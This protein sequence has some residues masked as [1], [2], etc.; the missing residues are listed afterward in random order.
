MTL[1]CKHLTAKQQEQLEQV[2]SKYT[3]FFSGKLGRYPHIKVHLDVDDSVKPSINALSGTSVH[4]N[5]FQTELERLVKIGVLEPCGRSEWASPTFI[6]PKKD[7]KVRWISDLR[8]LNEAIKRKVYPPPRIGDILARRTG[9][10]FFTKLDCSMQ[11]CAFEF[12]DES[13]ELCTISTPS[14]CVVQAHAYGLQPIQRHRPGG[15]RGIFKDI[16]DV[17][18][19]IDDV[20]CFSPDWESHLKLLDT[21]L[22]RLEEN[23]FTVNPSK[24]EWAVKETDWLGHWLTPTGLKPWRKKVDAIIKMQQPRNITQLR[25]FIGAVQYYRDMWPRRAHIL[26]PLTDLTGKKFV[27]QDKLPKLSRK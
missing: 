11:H 7:G 10:Q 3:K 13:A 21:V 19:Y 22:L 1:N 18:A 24:C 26:A 16:D 14:V 15:H 23:G 6:T 8:A 25:S 20:G 2:L 27:W 9:Y 4:F 12:D 5:T 17:E